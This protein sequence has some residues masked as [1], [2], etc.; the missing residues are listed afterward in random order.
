MK[1][2]IML[3]AGGFAREIL[4]TTDVINTQ[5]GT[6]I[7]PIG[8]VYDGASKDKGRLIHDIPVLGDISCLKEFD[9][10]KVQ[11]V[12]AVGRSVWR[13]KMV[14]EAK[15]LGGKFVSVIHPSV[16][17]SKSAKIG[18]GAIMQR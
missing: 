7:S 17:I 13:R 4:D 18:E 1:Q 9:L 6:D 11:L 8:F 14:E 3:G 10:K 15:K 2:I 5:T 16:T 12:A